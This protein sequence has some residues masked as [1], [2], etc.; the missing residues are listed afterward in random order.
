M[1]KVIFDEE[2][3]KSCELCIAVCPK[4]ILRISADKMNGKGY[5]PAEITDNEKCIGCAFCATMCPD[6]VITIEED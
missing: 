6:A 5:R 1:K 3:C 2:R 4:K